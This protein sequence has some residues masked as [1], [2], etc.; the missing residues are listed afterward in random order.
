MSVFLIFAGKV[1]TKP[2]K[3]E[4]RTHKKKETFIV[5]FH[6]VAT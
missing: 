2:L 1:I 3:V 6:S 5:I 4:K